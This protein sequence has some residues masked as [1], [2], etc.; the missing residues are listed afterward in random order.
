MEHLVFRNC[1]IN[2]FFKQNIKFSVAQFGFLKDCS[3]LQQ[4]LLLLHSIH[5]ALDSKSWIDT[6]YIWIF[7]RHSTWCHIH[8]ELLYKLHHNLWGWLQQYMVGRHHC[9]DINKL[10]IT[11]LTTFLYMCSLVCPWVLPWVHFFLSYNINNLLQ[12]IKDSL[13]FLF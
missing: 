9:V 2:L 10:I 6:I 13:V 7:L 8:M 3:C 5:N 11:Y 4:L 1:N 12:S